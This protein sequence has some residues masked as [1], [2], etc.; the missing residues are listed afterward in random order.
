ML[1]GAEKGV[2]RVVNGATDDLFVLNSVFG[3]AVPL[4]P[5]FQRLAI[6][7]IDPI[8]GGGGEI[9]GRQGGPGGEE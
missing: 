2:S 8:A 4:G 5:A 6:E 9:D 7:E 1:V 3:G